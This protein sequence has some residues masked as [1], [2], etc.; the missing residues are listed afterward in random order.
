MRT[1]GAH[2]LK[3]HKQQQEK[4]TSGPQLQ[5]YN[6]HLWV[7]QVNV[8]VL[9][10]YNTSQTKHYKASAQPLAGNKQPPRNARHV[11]NP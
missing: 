10:H 1:T 5:Q 7:L 6:R 9:Q 8:V 3:N 2:I 11:G 4:M